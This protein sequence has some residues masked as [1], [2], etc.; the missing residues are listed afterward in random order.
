MYQNFKN[1]LASEGVF[2]PEFAN[3]NMNILLPSDYSLALLFI[4]DTT[5]EQMIK[6]EYVDRLVVSSFLKENLF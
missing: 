3:F 6:P 4:G 2:L 5:I 1:E